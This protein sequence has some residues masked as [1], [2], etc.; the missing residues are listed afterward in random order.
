MQRRGDH[1]PFPPRV[2]TRDE[3][4]LGE[5]SHAVVHARIGDV[6]SRQFRDHRLVFEDGLEQALAHLRLVRRVR[7]V[8]FGPGDDGIHHARLVVLVGTCAEEG[9]QLTEMPILRRK[10]LHVLAEFKFGHGPGQIERGGQPNGRRNV[11]EQLLDAL[12]AE[13]P[14]HLPSVLVRM[15]KITET[16][17]R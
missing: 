14:Q 5:G 8:E 15:R 17:Q 3:R 10:P 13:R 2:L 7:G 4:R 16:R 12:N 1:D 6:R 9:H 11:T